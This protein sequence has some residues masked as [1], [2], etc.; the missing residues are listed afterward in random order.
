MDPLTPPIQTKVTIMGK[1]EI[2]NRKSC[3]AIFGTRP[4]GSQTP[5]SPPHSTPCQ[6]QPPLPHHSIPHPIGI[7][8][9]SLQRRPGAA[10]TPQTG[11]PA[12]Q[13]GAAHTTEPQKRRV[14]LLTNFA[15]FVPTHPPLPIQFMP[16]SIAG[17]ETVGPSP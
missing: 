12:V 6:P 16:H 2:Y 5:P 1:K 7:W 8:R 17:L 14:A 11:A 13:C 4:F 9:L 10:H 15:S 3:R